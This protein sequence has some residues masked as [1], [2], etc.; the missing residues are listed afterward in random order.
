[1]RNGAWNEQVSQQ[2]HFILKKYS[3]VHWN[4][5]KPVHYQAQSHV[6]T[7]QAYKYLQNVVNFAYVSISGLIPITVQLKSIP[8]NL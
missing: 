6:G 1:M 8:T 2:E 7:S 4:P 5:D 3:L